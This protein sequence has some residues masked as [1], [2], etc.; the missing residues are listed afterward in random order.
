MNGFRPD[1]R[2]I[3]TLSSAEHISVLIVLFCPVYI[4]FILTVYS[5]INC[6]FG[7]TIKCL[8][9]LQVIK[10]I[11]TRKRSI[12]R[13]T[14]ISKSCSITLMSP[15][16]HY[17]CSVSLFI[18]NKTHTHKFFINSIYILL[19]SKIECVK[20]NKKWCCS[21]ISDNNNCNFFFIFEENNKLN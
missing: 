7:P 6:A 15:G 13:N 14:N 9:H 18:S 10:W 16:F 3:K 19:L 21:S 1:F 12:K 5:T 20:L 2:P 4:F 8:L 17:I 11:N